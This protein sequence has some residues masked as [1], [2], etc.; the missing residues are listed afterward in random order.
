MCAVIHEKP[1]D[2][3]CCTVETDVLEAAANTCL[4]GG[5]ANDVSSTYDVS[6][7]SGVY[8]MICRHGHIVLV[9]M[10]TV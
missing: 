2:V 4:M 10:T 5:D 8:T 3:A 6:M 9:V 7:V 1:C